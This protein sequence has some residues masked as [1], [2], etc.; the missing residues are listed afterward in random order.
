MNQKIAITAVLTIA[1]ALYVA[2]CPVASA[3]DHANVCIVNKTGRFVSF[4]YGWHG[5]TWHHHSLPAGKTGLF[6]RSGDRGAPPRFL[7]ALNPGRNQSN[8]NVIP[9]TSSINGFNGGPCAVVELVNGDSGI[10]AVQSR[11]ATRTYLRMGHLAKDGTW[12]QYYGNGK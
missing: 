3:Q 9:L 11:G 1:G 8:Y 5:A 7:F 12:T 10:R 2:V 6:V 4:V